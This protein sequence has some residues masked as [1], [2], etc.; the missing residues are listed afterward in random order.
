MSADVDRVP[1]RVPPEAERLSVRDLGERGTSFHW[2]TCGSWSACW[3]VARG[4]VT[5][6][7]KSRI[8]VN[9]VGI[10]GSED[11]AARFATCWH[12]DECHNCAGCQALKQVRFPF[13]ARRGNCFFDPAGKGGWT[14]RAAVAKG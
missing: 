11:A 14:A 4:S 7:P 10:R 13:A 3:H 9:G 5:T 6:Q 8:V 1:R 12:G 2:A